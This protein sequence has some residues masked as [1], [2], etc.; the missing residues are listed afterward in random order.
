MKIKC[1][2][3]NV[4]ASINKRNNVWIL[5]IRDSRNE[6]PI[7]ISRSTKESNQRKAEAKAQQILAD[8]YSID[9]INSQAIG[10]SNEIRTVADMVQSYFNGTYMSNQRV[11]TPEKIKKHVSAM[12][13]RI[14]NLCEFFNSTPI[15]QLNKKLINKFIERRREK[16]V[17][18]TIQVEL[19]AL[20]AS[21]NSELSNSRRYD[22]LR[23][24]RGH[25][26]LD[27][28]KRRKESLKHQQFEAIHK[29]LE[30][31]DQKNHTH[32]ALFVELLRDTGVRW[33]QMSELKFN[34]IDWNNY[35]LTFT[36]EN[37]KT[38]EDD[39]HLVVIDQVLT[40]KLFRL[41]EKNENA[42]AKREFVFCST[43]N[44]N[45][46]FNRNTF[47]QAWYDAQE[48][49]GYTKKDSKGKDV[50]LFKPHDLKRT[51]IMESLDLGYDR[52]EIKAMTHNRSD[53]IFDGYVNT[54]RIKRLV[55]ERRDKR[56]NI[57]D[58]ENKRQAGLK[59]RFD[60]EVWT[61]DKL[62]EMEFEIKQKKQE[63]KESEGLKI[64]DSD[65]EI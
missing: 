30:E 46:I 15:D 57:I 62:E 26:S 65:I 28:K 25:W 36:R 35:I 8:L 32:F 49:I 18:G 56:Q 12:N 64:M 1:K 23:N 17:D 2:Y 58:E 16:V 44:S 13:A 27:T 63:L 42:E 22:V 24:S 33:G 47:Y 53:T 43:T 21:I 51:H 41:H 45:K 10:Q 20:F 31:S 11:H 59:E 29:K 60:N 34:M 61:L 40:D 7:Q 6:E 3:E 9:N 48:S 19:N 14:N 37:M 54:S 5:M 4:T 50:Y 38:K 39:V 55:T 52:S